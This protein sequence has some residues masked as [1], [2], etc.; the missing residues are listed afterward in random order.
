MKIEAAAQTPSVP[1]ELTP[2]QKALFAIIQSFI[3][4]LLGIDQDK[5]TLDAEFVADLNADSIELVELI[6]ATE[7]Q[8]DL[9]INDD[10]AENIRTARQAVMYV[11]WFL[12]ANATIKGYND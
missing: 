1:V 10:D 11:D 4:E 9:E 2:N 8:F 6:M 3:A 5:V 12:P 7:Q